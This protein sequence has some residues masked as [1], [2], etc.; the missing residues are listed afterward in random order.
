M[1]L[2]LKNLKIRDDGVIVVRR[3]RLSY[4]HIFEMWCKTPG[5]DK[6]RFSATFILPEETH[7]AEIKALRKHF[8]QLQQEF[9]KGKVAAKDLCFRDG[10][11]TAKPEYQDAW[12]LVSSQTDKKLAP[13]IRN[14]RGEVVD[15]DDG[16]IYAGCYVTGIVNPWK[17]ANEHGKKINAN[18][19]GVQYT[20]KGEAFSSAANPDVDEEFEEGEDEEAGD[21]L[22]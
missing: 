22:D 2:E 10:S 15:E 12:I 13:T 7:A 18:L 4:P 20:G 17:Q 1:A 11:Q 6:P 9:F 3:A 21:G 19:V 8:D 14:I 5:K 16:M